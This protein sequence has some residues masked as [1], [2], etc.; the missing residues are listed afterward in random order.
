MA[1]VFKWE[2]TA[3]FFVL[4]LPVLAD[5]GEDR[6]ALRIE[7]EQLRESGHLSIGGI[8]VA[9]GNLLADFYERRGSNTKFR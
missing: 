1:T 7:I 4:C 5:D 6:E 9:S 3:L 8:D 2:I